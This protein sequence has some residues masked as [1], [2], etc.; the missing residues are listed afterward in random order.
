M[1]ETIAIIGFIQS[2]FGVLL[3]VAKRP[4]HLSLTLLSVWFLLIAIFL[5][6]G[7]LPFEVVDY[8]KPGIFPI[9]F[10]FGPLL[11]FYVSSLAIE[12]FR[13]KK[14]QLLHVIPL[15]AVCIHR[16]TI[17]AVSISSSSN[18]VENPSYIYNKVYHI[19]LIISMFI[20]W[21]FSVKLILN[22]RKN[23]PFYFSNYSQKNTLSWLIFVVLIFLLVFLSDLLLFAIAKVFD[24]KVVEFLSLSA[25]LTA[26]TFIMVFFGINQSVIYKFSKEEKDL[27]KNESEE[28]YKR[29]GLGDKEIE[30]I[31][32]Q[33]FNYL[34]IKKPYLN[35]EFSLQMMVDDLGIS[36]QNISQVINTGQKKNFYKLINGFRVKEVKEKLLNPKYEHYTILGIA[37]ECGFN[38]KTSFNRIFKEETGLTPTEYK[39]TL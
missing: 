36:R 26:F 18:L 6:A 21:I 31:N 9:N 30:D 25:N 16:S 3:F 2:L 37:F 12:D 29:S 24:L 34:E 15:L 17:D 38:S 4:K 19:L 28:K 1:R 39:K 8:F 33:I 10:L 13:L 7:L 22:H 14:I 20:Y 23:I 5:G 35:T 27:L 32:S 11:Y